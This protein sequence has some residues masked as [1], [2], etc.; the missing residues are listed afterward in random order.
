[1]SPVSNHLWEPAASSRL[2]GVPPT[3]REIPPR[4]GP[5]VRR[6]DLDAF[7]HVEGSIESG[8]P[9]DPEGKGPVVPTWNNSGLHRSPPLAPIVA[10]DSVATAVSVWGASTT[11]PVAAFRLRHDAGAF[12]LLGA[13]I[14]DSSP[15]RYR[16]GWA[17]WKEFIRLYFGTSD[18]HT[19]FPE[20]AVLRSVG[21]AFVHYL[22]TDQQRSSPYVDQ[23]LSHVSHYYKVHGR[24]SDALRSP[25]V[26][27]VKRAVR[28]DYATRNEDPY[29]GRKLPFT[30]DMVAQAIIFHRVRGST[31]DLLVALAFRCG[32]CHLLRASEYLNPSGSKLSRHCI[33]AKHV[34]FQYR[35]GLDEMRLV[36]GADLRRLRIPYERVTVYK[37]TVPSAKNDVYR[38]G[39]FHFGSAHRPVDG[40]D[41]CR[42]LYAHAVSTTLLPDDPFFSMR[43]SGGSRQVLT[44]AVMRQAVKAAAIRLG[45]DPTK[46]SLHSLRIGGAC[47]LRATGAPLSMILFMGR[48]KSAPACLSYQVVGVNEYDRAMD[49]LRKPGV[50]SIADV[51]LLHTRVTQSVAY[52]ST[53]DDVE[54]TGFRDGVTCDAEADEEE[55]E[56]EHRAC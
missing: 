19:L 24:C 21:M 15:A 28:L 17:L 53:C 16:Q 51:E 36:S 13:C 55:E 32:F 25:A 46:F 48:W 3:R 39:R 7:R 30:G 20:G 34:L 9:S 4:L 1:M 45:V 52:S 29:P 10:T 43:T 23:T 50:L 47:A 33:L 5:S 54:S 38:T 27:G 41:I 49:Y 35:T 14:Q 31:G 8:Q 26:L 42:E 37:I 40:V 11:H 18:F 22:Y 12:S 44:Y 6:W 2:V 56:E